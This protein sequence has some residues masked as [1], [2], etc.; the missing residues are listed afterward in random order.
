MAGP[1]G[2]FWNTDV[3]I[4][5]GITLAVKQTPVSNVSETAGNVVTLTVGPGSPFLA[6]DTVNLTGLTARPDLI[7]FQTLIA[8]T[9]PTTLTFNDGGAFGVFPSTPET[10]Y[11]SDT[12]TFTALVVVGDASGSFLAQWDTNPVFTNPPTSVAGS[13]VIDSGCGM[14]IVQ[15]NS[16]GFTPALTI[17]GAPGNGPIQVWNTAVFGQAMAIDHLGQVSIRVPFG[18]PPSPFGGTPAFDITAGINNTNIQTWDTA[19]SNSYRGQVEAMG[20]FRPAPDLAISNTGQLV[21]SPNG[22]GI[23]SVTQ[24]DWVPLGFGSVANAVAT[25]LTL[26]SVAASSGGNA[27]YTG[28]ITGGA[29]NAFVNYSFVVSGFVNQSNNTA[30]GTNAPTPGHPLGYP[31]GFFICVASTATTLTL[32]N[33]FAVVETHAATATYGTTVYSS[34]A[35]SV[36][37]F[38]ELIGWLSITAVGDSLN[39][40]EATYSVSTL[41]GGTNLVQQYVN[42]SGFANAAN[43]GTFLCIANDTTSITVVNAHAVNQNATVTASFALTDVASNVSGHAVYTG[44]I[45]GGAANAYRGYVFVI[46]GF[47]GAQNNVTAICTESSATTLTLINNLATAETHAA[48]AVG[49]QSVA[50][51]YLIDE[52]FTTNLPGTPFV[53]QQPIS[54]SGQ[55][56]AAWLSGVS[57]FAGLS[58]HNDD[59]SLTYPANPPAPTLVISS[60]AAST[61][62]GPFVLTAVSTPTFPALDSAT[63]TGTISGGAGNAYAGYVFTIT[64]FAVSGNNVT[65]QICIASTATTLVFQNTTQTPETHA[66]SATGS[67]A[68]YTGTITG[69]AANGL[70]GHSF[71]VDG[72]TNAVNN[73]VAFCIASTAT[74]ITL[75][76]DAAV[77]ESASAI[78][79]F[80]SSVVSA[81]VFGET[82][83]VNGDLGTTDQYKGMW[84]DQFRWDNGGS[85]NTDTNNGTFLCVASSA[86]SM[87]LLNPIG[88][89][90]TQHGTFAIVSGG[91]NLQEWHAFG[92]PFAVGSISAL[93]VG[94]FSGVATNIITKTASY[95]VALSDHTINCNGTFTLTLPTVGL[96]DGQE[97]YI[98]N[99]GT[100]TV[101]ISSAVNIDGTTTLLSSTQYESFTL[102]WDAAA[103]QYWIY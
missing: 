38:S 10:G 67:S 54:L 7:G 49:S 32:M 52:A 78:A 98:K 72:F 66:G 24:G 6:G 102:Q 11:A 30:V 9:D 84:I 81:S 20:G 43:N 46:T 92:N 8:P 64:G 36:Q 15:G 22:P 5:Q 93:G 27:V 58:Q 3:T 88:T 103:N 56:T 26:T 76:N 40:G 96:I 63:Y 59:C 1:T 25:A 101:T 75:G 80:T 100:G 99:I 12:T 86:S 85:P 69:G 16:F 62:I 17:T 90:Q 44:T 89:A 50:T 70:R 97:F 65:S 95:T 33:P 94:K 42:V 4:R 73:I 47:T 48:T 31:Y 21:A 79:V 74:T 71:T 19:F 77:V 55:T 41:L 61:T 14:Q 23:A 83:T 68:V 57:T 35:A 2:L 53:F 87:T 45:T 28:T 82:G 29:N 34:D 51:I 39:S 91:N 18:S 37:F 60:V 13:V